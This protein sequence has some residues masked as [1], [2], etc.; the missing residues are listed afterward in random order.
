MSEP[1]VSVI[2]PI[3]NSQQYLERCLESL[4]SQTHG[5]LE[6]ICVNDG[7][8]DRSEE[9][10]RDRAAA[11]GRIKLVSKDNEG[12]PQARKTGYESSTAPYVLFVDSDD[13]IELNCIEELL[14]ELERSGADVASCDV[15]W[16]YEG[17]SHPSHIQRGERGGMLSPQEA[18]RAILERSSVFQYAWNKLYRREALDSSYFPIPS[19][20]GEDYFTVTHIIRDGR[21]SVSHLCKPLYHYIQRSTSMCKEGFKPS[22]AQAFKLYL[23][24]EQRTSEIW[25]G[26]SKDVSLYTSFEMLWQLLPME[27]NHVFEAHIMHEAQQRFRSQYLQ[28][29]T[30][31]SRG[32]FEK[33]AVTLAAVNPRLLFALYGV[34][35]RSFR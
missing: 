21:A 12:L 30:S 23:E 20:M 17:E 29:M 8:T 11:D 32:L 24:E 26:L 5:N 18:M 22:H 3:Y 35:E 25:S 10:I 14:R 27:R 6:I 7:S 13:W 34:M 31:K 1:T 2:V 28:L 15:Y 9:I 4:V 19:C 33:G 16:D